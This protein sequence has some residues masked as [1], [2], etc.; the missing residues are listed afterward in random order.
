MPSAK[1]ASGTVLAAIAIVIERFTPQG[2]R[3]HEG[4]HRRLCFRVPAQAFFV[5]N[6]AAKCYK[7]TSILYPW[8]L[9]QGHF[10]SLFLARSGDP[11]PMV[12]IRLAGADRGSGVS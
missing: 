2:L 6:Q 10:L 11:G 4:L 3:L 12:K 5:L 9:G 7:K 8:L 1:N